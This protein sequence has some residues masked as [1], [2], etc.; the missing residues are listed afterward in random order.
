MDTERRQSGLVVPKQ[1]PKKSDRDHGPL[2]FRDASKRGRIR[3]ALQNLWLE[4][5]PGGIRL[6]DQED[7]SVCRSRRRLVRAL[8]V[9]LLGD[10]VEF[11]E[12]T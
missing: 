5:T 6:P 4:V 2:E 3:E 9:E 7:D 11:W 8:A 12:Y 1:K 10:G